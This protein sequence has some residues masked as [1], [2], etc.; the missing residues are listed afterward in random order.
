MTKFFNTCAYLFK[1]NINSW[2][3][4]SGTFEHITFNQSF[5][6]AFILLSKLVIV[7]NTLQFSQN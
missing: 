4:N 3:L 5:F 2:I 7:I 1:A 6:T